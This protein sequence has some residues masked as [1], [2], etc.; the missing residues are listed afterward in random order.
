VALAGLEVV[1]R[2][3]YALED[4]VTPVIAGAVQLV[5]MALLAY[6]FTSWLFPALGWAALGGLALGVSISNLLETA[7][8]LWLLRRKMAGIDGRHLLDGLWRIG[9]AGI[10]MAAVALFTRGYLSEA[11]AFW[12]LLAGTLTAGLTYL[13]VT[14]G[15]GL[16]EL[17]QVLRRVASLTN[18]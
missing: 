6:L 3:F 13:L 17:R 2:A 8:L 9:S 15:L 11:S 4:T 18:R 14:F 1:S 5:L 16:A 10:V 12:Q 7:V